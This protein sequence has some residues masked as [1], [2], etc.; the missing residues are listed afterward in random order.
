MQNRDEEV[1]EVVR[2]LCTD[3]EKSMLLS[4][5]LREMESESP[6][7]RV[8]FRFGHWSPEDGELE[9]QLDWESISDAIQQELKAAAR[10]SDLDSSARLDEE[11]L[12]IIRSPV[13]DSEK[14]SCLAAILPRMSLDTRMKTLLAD[15]GCWN[16]T[17]ARFDGAPNWVA[18]A[19]AIERPATPET[20]SAHGECRTMLERVSLEAD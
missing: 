14:T 15:L 11:I 5:L 3:D 4:T 12:E 16:N 17:E 13:L 7:V 6:S 1:L 18:L 10:C 20:S 8:F 2:S 19:K 9:G